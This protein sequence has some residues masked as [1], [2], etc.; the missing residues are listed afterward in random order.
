M[1]TQDL[2]KIWKEFETINE[3]Y[4]IAN[5]VQARLD[6]LERVKVLMKEIRNLEMT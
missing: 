6:L 3:L 1:N 5:S 2:E 4:P